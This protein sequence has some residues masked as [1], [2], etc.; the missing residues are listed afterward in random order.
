MI[1]FSLLEEDCHLLL[2]LWSAL[3]SFSSSSSSPHGSLKHHH[4]RGRRLL[5]LSPFTATCEIEKE[6]IPKEQASLFCPSIVEEPKRKEETRE[7]E[8]ET[9][10]EIPISP[11]KNGA[12]HEEK[13]TPEL[14]TRCCHHHFIFLLLLLPL[15]LLLWDLKQS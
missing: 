1:R 11:W 7:R 14:G 12:R 6:G 3:D 4:I 8:K 2:L 9:S 10:K 13:E 5:F 15:L